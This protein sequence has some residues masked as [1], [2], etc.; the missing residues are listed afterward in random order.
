MHKKSGPAVT[1]PAECACRFL[2]NRP[3]IGLG[4]SPFHEVASWFS[5]PLA[6]HSPDIFIFTFDLC[7]TSNQVLLSFIIVDYLAYGFF[8]TMISN[9][10]GSSIENGINLLCHVLC[11]LFCYSQQLCDG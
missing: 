4:S 5:M 10:S 7:L 8:G 11:W 1:L 9:A 3:V 6:K 2:G